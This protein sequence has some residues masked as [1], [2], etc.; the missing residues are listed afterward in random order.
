MNL[1][2]ILKFLKL[3]ES[4]VR[5]LVVFAII[6]VFGEIFIKL[7]QPVGNNTSVQS[8]GDETFQNIHTVKSGE[9]LWKIAVQYFGDGFKWVEIAEKNNLSDNDSITEGQELVIPSIELSPTD[10]P[11]ISPLPTASDINNPANTSSTSTEAKTYTVKAGDTLWSISESEIGSGYNW[12]DIKSANKLKNANR[13][14]E[15]QLLFIPNVNPKQKTVTQIA[16][17]P[18]AIGGNDY[19]V[20]RGDNLWEIAVRA[21]G[22]GYRWTEIAKANNLQNPGVIVP[23]QTL[24]IPR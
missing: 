9:N 7:S 10:V 12:I 11:T 5:M 21:Y 23:N 20:A 15:G 13:I 24:L 16:P 3:N 18:S 8:I 14:E 17:K 6:V 4:G 2:A 22:D 1:K 19:V